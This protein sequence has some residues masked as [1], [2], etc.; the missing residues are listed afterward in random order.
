[1]FVDDIVPKHRC[2]SCICFL[3]YNIIESA[4]YGLSKTDPYNAITLLFIDGCFFLRR[5]QTDNPRDV[6]H[7]S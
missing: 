7:F 6:E 4:I 3:S 2:S 5:F 1:M